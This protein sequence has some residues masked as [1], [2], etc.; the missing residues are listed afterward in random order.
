MM[1]GSDS[2]MSGGGGDGG[3]GLKVEA[4]DERCTQ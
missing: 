3:G 4:A 1:T 2:C